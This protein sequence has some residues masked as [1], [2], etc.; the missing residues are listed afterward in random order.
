MTLKRALSLTLAIV[1]L[2]A[3]AT[4][5]QPAS[6]LVTAASMS[7]ASCYSV[8]VTATYNGLVGTGVNIVRVHAY[9]T[10]Q[11]LPAGELGQVDSPTFGGASGT[12]SLRVSF[13][14]KPAAGT[15]ISLLV[16]Q[17]NPSPLQQVDFGTLTFNCKD[18][19]PGPPIPP[20]FAQQLITCDA[21]LYD[22]PSGNVIPNAVVKAGQIW[23][24]NPTPVLDLWGRWW[25]AIFVGGPNVG[26]ISTACV[27]YVWQP[28]PQPTAVAPGYYPSYYYG[29]SYIVRRG[30][31][32]GIIARRFGV[33]LRA[34]AA[35]NGIWN[36]NRIY[37]GQ[38]IYI[39]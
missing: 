27:G 19:V 7:A 5:V 12:V 11:G 9:V 1:F 24:V 25:T 36:V 8:I 39:P 34:L 35:Y 15:S 33:S 20:G 28:T 29:T 4:G 22:S 10:S 38:I 32:L 26:Y 3:F 2:C 16:S 13:T 37:V 30:D 23:Y 14:R 6:A 21:Q 17:I 31:T 18:P